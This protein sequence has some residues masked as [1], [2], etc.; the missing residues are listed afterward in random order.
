VSVLQ[1]PITLEEWSARIDRQ[2][3]Y[4][5][6]EDDWQD[7]CDW[8]EGRGAYARLAREA[9][10][11]DR[12]EQ[13]ESWRRDKINNA[14]S[15]VCRLRGVAAAEAA[16]GRWGA[17]TRILEAVADIETVLTLIVP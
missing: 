7:Y 8:K 6:T 16:Q 12:R 4:E 2:A 9:E 1:R 5:P 13:E 14:R 10:L 15:A 17:H 11:E 3:N